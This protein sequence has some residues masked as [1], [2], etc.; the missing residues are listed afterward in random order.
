MRTTICPQTLGNDAVARHI[1]AMQSDRP[2]PD[3]AT[4]DP[5][6]PEG[7]AQDATRAD[8]TGKLLVAMPGMTDPRFARSVVC[9]CAHSGDGSMG[10]VINRPL[11]ELRLR[12]LLS[13]LE[14]APGDAPDLPVHYGGPVESGRGFVLHSSDYHVDGATLRVTS[15]L[16]MT[17]TLEVLS[18]F[19]AGKGPERALMA[20]GYAGWAPGQLEA[21]FLENGWLSVDSDCELVFQVEDELKWAGAL[22]AMGVD[23]TLLSAAAGHA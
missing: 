7:A 9:I 21:E 1:C 5:T 15:S 14:L 12:D 16:A 17:A 19:S 8:L 13:R 20:L 18:D 6:H 11:P 10:L 2:R 23:P 3:P 4:C 22:A